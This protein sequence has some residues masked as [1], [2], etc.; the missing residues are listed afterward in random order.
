MKISIVTPCWNYGRFLEKNL[1]SVYA[2]LQGAKDLEVEH[3][4]VDAG[5]TDGTVELLAKWEKAHVDAGNYTFR[6]KSEPDKGQTDAINK[7][8]RQAT[9][10]AVCWLNAD[11]TYNPG[12]LAAVAEYLRRHPE[13]DFVYGEVE[14]VD[15]DGRLLRRKRDHGFSG[16]V[17]LYY[18][19]YMA[20]AA[21]F[22]RRRVLEDGVCLD[23]SFKVCMDFDYWVRIH[24]HGYRFG[25]LPKALS[26]FAWHDSNVSSVFTERRREERLKVQ[27]AHAPRLFKSDAAQTRFIDAMAFLAHQWRRV[28]IVCRRVFGR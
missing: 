11:E 28:L 4:I 18:G 14:F 21:S 7:G 12:A 22:W 9:G 2:Q 16:F 3:V 1:E 26:R 20:S 13:K 10:D 25:F 6:W 15:A 17:L 23:P 24:K 27:F 19:C 5:S 8:L